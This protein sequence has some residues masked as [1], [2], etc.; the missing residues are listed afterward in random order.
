M[1]YEVITLKIA[2]IIA[3]KN[4]IMDDAST[5]I[6][7]YFKLTVDYTESVFYLAIRNRHSIYYT[8]SV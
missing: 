3:V 6:I 8:D 2:T 1:L 7:C 4:A 5:D